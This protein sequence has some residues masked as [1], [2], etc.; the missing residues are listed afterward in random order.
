MK[1]RAGLARLTGWCVWPPHPPNPNL[2]P[3]ESHHMAD[4]LE[5]LKA[6]LADR[7]AIDRREG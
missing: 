5:Q 3:R 1:A 2:D 7:Y 4:L 6:A